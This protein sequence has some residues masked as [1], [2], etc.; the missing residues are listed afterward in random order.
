MSDEERV[1]NKNKKIKK[2]FTNS[3]KSDI[4]VLS[5]KGKHKKIKIKKIKKVLDKYLK[6]CYNKYVK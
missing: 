6:K 2:L 1:K 5:N 4:I 3:K